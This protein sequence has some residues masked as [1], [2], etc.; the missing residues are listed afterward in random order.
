MEGV[1]EDKVII[2]E[3]RDA[4]DEEAL[5]E[6]L[7][8]PTGT[9]EQVGVGVEEV[10]EDIRAEIM[11]DPHTEINPI[12][13]GQPMGTVINAVLQPTSTDNPRR[14]EVEEALVDRRLR[15][16]TP[17]PRQQQEQRRSNL[18]NHVLPLFTES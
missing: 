7:T 11:V 2:E 9:S 6:V 10:A 15:Q 14:T 18:R 13:V 16:A 4:A 1:V 5:L 3:V 17:R 8:R 12:T